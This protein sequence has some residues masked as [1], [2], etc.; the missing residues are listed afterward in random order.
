MTEVTGI[1]AL[2]DIP[3]FLYLRHNLKQY[4]NHG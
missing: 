2:L 1:L 3:A 4:I